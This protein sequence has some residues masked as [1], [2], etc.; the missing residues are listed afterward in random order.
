MRLPDV[1]LPVFSGNLDNW[2]NFHDLFVSLV[3]SSHELSNIQKFYYLR[4]S[5]SGDA[6]K[7]IQT[8]A[9]TANNYLVAWSLLED[10]YQNPA[11]LKKSYVDSLFEFPSLKRESATELRS[12]VERFEAN[13][14]VLKQL[15]EKT[16]FWD[17]ILIRML[18]IRLDP[19]TRR[20]WEE[21]S[22]TQAA[23]SFQDLTAFIQRRV[24]V[25]ETIGKSTEC[26]T[27]NN[28][29]K[30]MQR[31]IASHGA[32]QSGSRKCAIC[33][34]HHPLYQCTT[35]SKLAAE[36]KEKEI[37]QHQLCRNCLRKGHQARDCSSTS[38]CRH[39]RGRHHSLLCNGNSSSNSLKSSDN[40]QPKQQP[41]KSS[42]EQPS[43]SLSA[44][45]EN[46]PCFAATRYQRKTVLLAT[47]NI[48]L[49]DDNGTE[50]LA[51]AL[52]DSGSECCFMTQ[53]FSQ[54]VKGQRQKLWCPVVGI[55]Q[56]TTEAR[57]KLRST[58]RSRVCQYST[59][60]DFLILPKVTID[61][62]SASI[63]ASSWE[64]Q[65]GIE[66]ADPSFHQSSKIDV[67]LGAEIFFD[68]FKFAGRIHLGDDQPSLINSVLGCVL[69]Q[70][71]QLWRTWPL[72]T[73]SISLWNDFGPSK[74]TVHPLAT[75]SKKRRVKIIFSKMSHALQRVDTVFVYH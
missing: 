54:L 71:N 38:S 49:I 23:I 57:Y 64:I 40:T 8:I 47:A 45:L 34:E 19:T 22:S 35:F 18:S 68:I 25:L 59:S 30:P 43:V 17:V 55:G 1:K 15:G 32:F 60:L 11:R 46:A 20:D 41:T 13:V 44:T 69:G 66:L 58:I 9:I 50:H 2:M 24:T 5:L 7:L 67:I 26:S 21:F 63:D 28:P 42:N 75:L 65:P 12:L 70:R 74:T 61:L 72:S 53:S 62:P 4:S 14:K 51:R 27:I 29:K 39:C 10:H 36:D 52:L 3:H 37:R 56:S 16:E 48:K 31:A 33:T 6:L 73:I